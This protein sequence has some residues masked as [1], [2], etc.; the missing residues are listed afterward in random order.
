MQKVLG[1]FLLLLMAFIH[2]NGQN[3][4]AAAI[5]GFNA[6]QVNGD[7]L[8][9]FHK[10]G[11]NFGAMGIIPVSPKF[12]VSL[13]IL[14]AQKGSRTLPNRL[15]PNRTYLLRLNYADV[16]ILVNYNDKNQLI[17]GLGVSVGT[18]VKS[19]EETEGN[20]V[21]H[22]PEG[23]YKKRDLQYV[24]SGTFMA[25]PNI[26]IN[27]RYSYSIV[28][29]GFNIP[30]PRSVKNRIEEQYSSVAT[31]RLVYYFGKYEK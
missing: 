27:L 28:P 29:M 10:I 6:T 8:A 4:R 18:L 20:P 26:G 3:I 31:F 16:P 1:L 9:G 11:L 2:A 15:D 22:T 13:E 17:F 7:D 21:I 25:T 5:G 14:Y 12:S 23:P 30:F 19:L 24:I